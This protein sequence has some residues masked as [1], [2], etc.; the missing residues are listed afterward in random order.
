MPRLAPASVPSISLVRAVHVQE[1]KMVSVFDRVMSLC[2]P[3]E[4]LLVWH[5][6]VRH[7]HRF[8]IVSAGRHARVCV[9]PSVELLAWKSIRNSKESIVAGARLCCDRNK[10]LF[11][12][13][14][15]AG[16]RDC[17][18]I[19]FRIQ[20]LEF[21]ERPGE[22]AHGYHRN[23]CKTYVA[24]FRVKNLD[25]EPKKRGHAHRKHGGDCEAFFAASKV[26]RREQ[27]F[28]EHWIKRELGESRSSGK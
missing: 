9:G 4:A 8:K 26:S 14:M 24:N 13:V 11:L 21:R 5:E 7:L 23:G 6:Y 17:S 10:Q 18:W 2:R 15:W 16:T 25:S 1:S 28:G 3:F 22:I 12:S 27:E 20:G 19:G